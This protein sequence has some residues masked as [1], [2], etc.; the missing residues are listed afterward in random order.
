MAKPFLLTILPLEKSYATSKKVIKP[1][2][3]RLS[4]YDFPYKSYNFQAALEAFKLGSPYRK[5]DARDR[6][7]LLFKLAELI[8]RDIAYL[9]VKEGRNNLLF[10]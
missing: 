9:A 7:K 3:T 1:I 8:E 4:K 6:G 2:S 5:M 10:F